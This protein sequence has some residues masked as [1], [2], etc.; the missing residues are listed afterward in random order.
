[1]ETNW[2]DKDYGAVHMLYILHNILPLPLY[3][4]L[5]SRQTIQDALEPYFSNL[6]DLMRNNNSLTVHDTG[7]HMSCTQRQ[8]Y[9][10]AAT[11]FGDRQ[12]GLARNICVNVLLPNSP[13]DDN[14]SMWA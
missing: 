4:G 8:L 1:M 12:F 9:Q 7:V 13:G 11:K 5:A 14:L 10:F 3:R 6:I 2:H